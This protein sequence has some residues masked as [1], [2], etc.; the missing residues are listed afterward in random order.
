M[1]KSTKRWRT[2]FFL[3][4]IAA[5]CGSLVFPDGNFLVNA[6][7][8]MIIASGNVVISEFRFRGSEGASDEF[9][10]I[11]N[12]TSAQI[13]LNGWKL[14]GSNS[15]GS[16]GT[17]YTFATDV[18]LQPGQH[19]LLANIATVDG[20]SADFTY[21]TGIT[22]DGGVAL[23]RPDNS[24]VDA[25]GLSSGSAYKEGTNLASI[26]S[27]MDQSYERKLG[28]ASASCQDSDNNSSDFQSLNPSVPQNL[29]S[30]PTPCIGIT[31]ITSTNA[32]GAY[33]SG[34][35]INITVTFGGV[36]NVTGVPSLLLETGGTDRAATYASGSGTN[37]LTFSY[38]VVTGDVSGD[39]DY[40]ANNSL[41]L[42]G[43]TIAAST[44]D[45]VL[46]L[47][48]PGSPG[49]LG[50]NKNIV[51]DNGI[52]PSVT[53][54]QGS[55]QAD[56]A[57]TLPVDFAVVFS[58]PIDPG[59]FTASDITQSGTAS[60]ITWTIVDSG[61]HI[62][63]TLRATAITGGG[64]VVPSI[65]ANAVTDLAANGNTASTSTDNSVSYAAIAPLTVIINEVAWSGTAANSD[66]EWIELYNP[67][68]SPVNITGWQ[69][70]G[71]DNTV[72]RVGNPNIALSGTI[73]AGGYFLLERV[74]Q[75]TNV[76]ADQI[77]STG[78][79]VNSGERLYLKD[80]AG[81][82]IDTANVDGGAWPAGTAATPTTPYPYAS[83]E[84]VSTANQWVT[85]GGTVPIAQDRNGGPIRGT[86]GAAN[87]IRSTS[88]TTITSDTP[89]PSLINANVTVTVTV[90][91]GATTPTGTVNISGANTNC[92][93][94][95]SGGTGSCVVR[96]TTAG[97]KT[98][99]AT[100]VSNSGHPNSNDTETHQVNTSSV[101]VPTIVPTNRPPPELVA[102]NEF[103]PR[104]GHDWNNDG[105]V[106][107]GDEYIELLNH[108]V[109]NVNL[110]GYSL[111]DEVNVG[112]SPFRLPSVTIRPGERIVF[113]GSETGLLLSDGGDGV[114]L[115]K[116]NGQLADA[117][118]YTIVGY[119]DQSYCRLPDNG[120]ADDWNQTCFPTPGLQNSLS[121]VSPVPANHADTE[122]YCPIADTLPDDFAQAECAP[123]GN[124]IWDPAY[125]DQTGW[126]GE[127]YL[128]GINGKWPVFAN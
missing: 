101:V 4:I 59:S 122:L 57:N 38:T 128:P 68:A 52:P 41:A 42:N 120:G 93:I 23:L 78:D 85:Y 117:F 10:E 13:N 27:D 121:G 49:S 35:V 87:W 77:Y 44:G 5:L 29:A 112:S 103:V 40:V 58:E 25:V 109:V 62:N 2:R 37:T 73:A 99:T 9:V 16:T 21:G 84:R 111:D 33:T 26:T 124:N 69:L 127:K 14:N 67:G 81:N 71:D 43:G 113:Y 74:E 86:P 12:P 22:A 98:I 91:G 104:P 46:I 72:N 1:Q 19:L 90:I 95:L 102:I 82:I 100:Y 39:L 31:N 60:G 15:S 20:V 65:A 34:A 6:A 17:R 63:F 116:P 106:N 83:M 47:P 51:I 107:V 66:D 80:N 24:I 7:P 88:I 28:G 45:A 118:N 119:P 11:F 97:T 55:S 32:D 75:A 56:P 3:L 108:G 30:S 54:N 48:N 36:V 61:D 115:L 76:T 125:W 92:S 53:V 79:L 8:K 89:D 126:Y 110:N 50:A 105:V 70:Y 94:T 64:T 18:T 96:F 114:R 123:F